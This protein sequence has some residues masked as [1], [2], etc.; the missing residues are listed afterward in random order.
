MKN[1]HSKI[2]QDV[3]KQEDITGENT[4]FQVY[5]CVVAY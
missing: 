4:S 5:H 2:P 1:A 3:K